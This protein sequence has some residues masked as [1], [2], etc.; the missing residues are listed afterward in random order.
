MLFPKG[1]TPHQALGHLFLS[2]EQCCSRS[3][4]LLSASVSSFFSGRASTFPLI[5]SNFCSA[6][7]RLCSCPSH[8]VFFSYHS[9]PSYHFLSVSLPFCILSFFCFS[10]SSACESLFMPISLVVT[11]ASH[12]D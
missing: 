3:R 7:Q 6:C 12:L 2:Q 8:W 10:S 1:I 4:L 9:S 11:S 5:F